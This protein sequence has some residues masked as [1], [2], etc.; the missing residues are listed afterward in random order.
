MS[1]TAEERAELIHD[2]TQALACAAHP[3]LSDEELQW[4]RLAIQAESRKIKFRDAIIEKTVG[5]LIVM[6]I[7]AVLGTIGYLIVD[8]AKNHGLK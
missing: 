4:V 1:L 5:A 7:S 6:A 3:Q 2:F 8:F